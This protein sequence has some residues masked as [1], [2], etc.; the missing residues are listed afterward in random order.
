MDRRSAPPPDRPAGRPF[1]SRR[2]AALLTALFTVAFVA[3]LAGFTAPTARAAGPAPVATVD[4]GCAHPAA[5][6]HLRCFGKLRAHRTPAGRLAP[7]TTGSPTTVGFVPSDLHAAYHL[8]GT[9]GGGRTV[10]IVDAQDDPN[11]ES[12]LAAYRGAY[13]L[14]ACTTA[15][16]CFR[17]TNQNGQASPL[18]AGDYGWA[19]EI[20]LDLDMVSAVCPDCHI[21]LVEANSATT[22]DLSAAEDTAAATPGV[23]AVSN[24]WG[25]AEDTTITAADSH[26]NHPGVAVTASS[27]DSGYGVSWPASSPYVTAVGGTSLTKASNARGWSE[28]AWGS[29]SGGNGAGSGCSAYEPKPA[30]QHDTGCAKRT[31]AD[32]SAVADPAT[33]VAVHDTYN[34]CG[35]SSWCDVLLSL[36]LAQGAD[37]WVEVGGTSAS[38]PIIASVYALAGNTASVNAGSYPYAHTSALNDVT[39]GA[40]G[41]CGGG[42]LCT[43]GPGYD[44][45]TGLGTPNGT[46]AF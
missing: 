42:Y 3:G 11:A 41:S 38:S 36:G 10:A 43:A 16:G 13:G 9:S 12:D 29:A 18:P 28:S 31:V 22:D 19:E 5:A 45:P 21:L 30:W 4:F 32:V 15:N 39:S 7:M 17:K 46:G 25:G 24:S 27:G 35:T 37:G 6:G 44:G 1:R 26:F 33:G 34:S 40:N 2:L 20:S 23:V 14:P 8:D